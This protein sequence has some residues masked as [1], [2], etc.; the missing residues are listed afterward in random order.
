MAELDRLEERMVKKD[1]YYA[2][3]VKVQMLASSLANAHRGDVSTAR[4]LKLGTEK[5]NRANRNSN[6]QHA[7]T[8]A[9]S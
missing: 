1:R 5:T 4:I 7:E 9:V 2:P 3:P 6:G 8:L